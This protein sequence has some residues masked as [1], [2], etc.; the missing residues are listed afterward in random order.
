M[1]FNEDGQIKAK[2]GVGAQTGT[3]AR[4][5]ASS[6]DGLRECQTID[7][8]DLWISPI[9]SIPLS[10]ISWKADPS[11]G[12][13][14]Q[15]ANKTSSRVEVSFDV[16]RSTSLSKSQRERLFDCFGRVVRASCSNSRSQARNKQVAMDRLTNRIA[17]CLKPSA[18]RKQSRPSK[19]AKDRRLRVKH[20]RS[21]LKRERA[22]RL[23]LNE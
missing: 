21:A 3:G 16:T 14:G 20:E 18:P 12:P 23:D 13:G 2:R 22:Q 5:G 10:E 8:S 11:G 1:D 6:D 4:T 19:A 9:L 17:I 7:D 15:H